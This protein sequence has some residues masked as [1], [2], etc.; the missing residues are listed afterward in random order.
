MLTN[1]TKKK[2]I[3]ITSILQPYRISFYYKLSKVLEDRCDLIIYH[4]TKEKEDGRPAFIGPVPFREKG[5]PIKTIKILSFTIVINLGMFKSV[6]EYNPDLIIMQGIS[7]DASLRLIARWAKKQGRK[8][9]FWTCG[10]EPG[11]AKGWQL[12][13]KNKYVSSFFRKANYHLTYSSNATKYVESMG[14]DNS[15][16]ETCYNGIETDDLFKNTTEIIRKSKEVRM[17]YNLSDHTTFLFVGGLILEKKVNLLIDSFIELLKKYDK[18]KLLII[19]DGPLKL[20]VKE[21]LK[22]NDDLKIIFLGRIIDG[23]DPYFAASDCFV[24]PGVGG[25][26]LNQAM[27]WGKTCIVSKADGTEDD[28]VIEGI[29]GYRF[30][31]NDLESLVSAMDR[32][33]NESQNKV[34]MM[35]ENSHQIII[36]KSNVN[37]MV[38]IFSSTIDNLLMLNKKDNSK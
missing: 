19:G 18:I 2:I 21:K 14:V 5:F 12:T 15:I 13:L 26:A 10:W 9:I 33:I 11:L 31:E 23:V 1:K 34:T 7:G 3:L 22:V 36:N 29:T 24:L 30:K 20:M 28:L 25:L 27:F 17:E 4:G 32:R 8:L 16:I 37:N 38:N 35:S 6:R